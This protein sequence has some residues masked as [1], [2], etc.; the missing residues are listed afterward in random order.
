MDFIELTAFRVECILGLLER[1]Q[2][3]P[4]SLDIEVKMGVDMLHAGENDDLNTSINYAVVCHQL[5][6]IAKEGHWRLLESMILAM[7][8]IILAYPAEDEERALVTQ[9]EISLRKPDV[10][11]GRATPGIR[12]TTQGPVAL[13]KRVFAPGVL[14]EVLQENR[15]NG[16]YRVQIAPGATWAVPS[17]VSVLGIVGTL[18]DGE[19]FEP[20]N[21]RLRGEARQLVNRT[22]KPAT[23]L[24]VAFPTLAV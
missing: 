21:M 1:E 6:F 16:A 12:V 8:R 3:T 15:R 10:L 19:E 7:S 11:E 20:G 4:Q 13:A 18:F 23:L 22:D 24:A 5:M 17:Q 14:A 2:H 9:V